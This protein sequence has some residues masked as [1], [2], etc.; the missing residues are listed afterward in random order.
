MIFQV[1]YFF[2]GCVW[3][4][5]SRNF[6]FVFD[7]FWNYFGKMALFW[8]TVLSLASITSC[9][10]IFIGGEQDVGSPLRVAQCR[11]TCL[12]RVRLPYLYSG[13]LLSHPLVWKLFFAS[14]DWNKENDFSVIKCTCSIWFSNID[15]NSHE[16]HQDLLRS[17]SD[18]SLN[19]QHFPQRIVDQLY[20]KSFQHNYKHCSMLFTLQQLSC[21]SWINNRR[22]RFILSWW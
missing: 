12:E 16:L 6:D 8:R 21:N 11:A 4:R 2:C 10:A 19:F 1:F 5:L 7:F 13:L 14:S 20:R 3:V 9:M 15:T 17:R 18:K 22:G